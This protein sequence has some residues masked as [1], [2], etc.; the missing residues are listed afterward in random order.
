M[1][2]SFGERDNHEHKRRWGLRVSLVTKLRTNN[3]Q[4]TMGDCP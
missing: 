1:K 4:D 2:A 3:S